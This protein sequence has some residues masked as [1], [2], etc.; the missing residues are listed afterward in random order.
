[1]SYTPTEWVTGDIVTANKLNN[2]EQGVVDAQL[3]E[4]SA[5]D[6]GKVFTVG[7]GEAETVVIVPEQTLTV[8]D[9]TTPTVNGLDE[10]YFVVGQECTLTVNGDSYAATVREMAPNDPTPIIVYF[11]ATVTYGIEFISNEYRFFVTDSDS[12]EPVPGT[13]T[14]TLTA[15]VPSVEPKWEAASGG[16]KVYSA[17]FDVTHAT[18]SMVPLLLYDDNENPVDISSISEACYI[19]TGQESY[20]GYGALNA[21]FAVQPQYGA[22]TGFGVWSTNFAATHLVMVNG[23]VIVALPQ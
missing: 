12:D 21:I 3:P 4:Y 22:G 13:Y 15:S 23:T 2:L 7:E 17:E 20:P 1:M 8:T 9:D 11:G 16:M 18:S 19:T 6:I 10:A 5:S 14:V